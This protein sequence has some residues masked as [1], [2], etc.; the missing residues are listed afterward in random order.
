LSQ[1]LRCLW[2]TLCVVSSNAQLQSRAAGSTTNTM[3]ATS[4]T[5]TAAQ[6]TQS[7]PHPSSSS[8][9][10][11]KYLGQNLRITACA[12]QGGRKYMEDRVHVHVHR[13][14]VT[15]AVDW[16]YVSVYDGHG[17]PE[18]SEYCRQHLLKNIQ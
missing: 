11:T 18:A 3:E 16:T 17:G 6:N 5:E 9:S 14:A 8:F 10:A 2:L 4:S 1:C 7:Q 12:N 15:G 13:C